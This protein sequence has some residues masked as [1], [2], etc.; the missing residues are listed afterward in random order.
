MDVQ[1]MAGQNCPNPATG[2]SDEFHIWIGTRPTDA[3]L[4]IPLGIRLGFAK[5]PQGD[6]QESRL[7]TE[8]NE[9]NE[10]KIL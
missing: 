7:R 4:E 5:G 1:R 10:L 6:L 3:G 8:Q 2:I 9:Q